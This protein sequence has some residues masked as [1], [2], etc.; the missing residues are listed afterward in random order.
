MVQK[1]WYSTE[2]EAEY[3][4]HVHAHLR[5]TLGRFWDVVATHSAS[6]GRF[7]DAISCIHLF[8]Y[9]YTL[10]VYFI[11]N[12]HAFL[13]LFLLVMLFFFFVIV[14]V[15]VVA[16]SFILATGFVILDADSCSTLK[17]EIEIRIVN[18]ISYV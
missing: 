2:S 17:I 5:C 8:I 3:S 9:S 13:G 16:F 12:F 15:T 18:F 4:A 10:P 1:I 6:E 7:I 11:K 14:V